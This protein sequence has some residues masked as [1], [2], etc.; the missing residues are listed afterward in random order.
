[1]SRSLRVHEYLLL[2][3]CLLLSLGGGDAS[4]VQ[5]GAVTVATVPV[6]RVA[7]GQSDRAFGYEVGEE[8]RYVLEPERSLRPG[9]S[10]WWSI[11]LHDIRGEG[12]DTRIIF[13]LEH[14]RSELIRDLFGG[15]VGRMQVVEV[16]GRLTVNR[17]GFPERLVIS[18]QH[19]LSGEMGSQSEIRT[20]L[21]TFDGERMVKQV[22][23]EGRE[24]KF[25]IAIAS[26][27]DLDLAVP[28]GLYPYVPTGLRCLGN[29]SSPGR[30]S[31]CAEGDPAFANPGL[32][33]LALP[34]MWEEQVNEKE[35]LFFMPSGV[36]TLPSGLMN[37]SGWMRR[38]RDTLRNFTR[39]YE[40]TDLEVMDYAQGVEIGPR[41]V[42][43]W[44]LDGSGRMGELYTDP[45]G[46]VLRVNIEPHPVTH[47]KR[48]IRLL[49]PSEY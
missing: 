34:V 20:T 2:L 45:D 19:D 5:P 8:R 12:D 22:R 47:G 42:D 49:F 36:G 29:P 25:N 48:W 37:M 3:A 27:D 14:E 1:M 30:P 23:L 4:A 46:R 28:Y 13:D 32:L 6:F 41:T 7:P 31:R 38:E 18:E 39:Y 16:S 11:V 21:F 26:H 24:W 35:F 33:S 9:E 15:S 40:K 17:F 10:A 44:H 43:A